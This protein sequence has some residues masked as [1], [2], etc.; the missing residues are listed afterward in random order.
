MSTIGDGHDRIKVHLDRLQ[1]PKMG[2]PSEGCE[3]EMV[4]MSHGNREFL[5]P[6]EPIQAL[7]TDKNGRRFEREIALIYFRD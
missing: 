4:M 7:M 2:M 1:L 6:K 5:V 3:A